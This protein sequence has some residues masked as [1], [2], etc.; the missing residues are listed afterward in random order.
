MAN[1]KKSYPDNLL[2]RLSFKDNHFRSCIIIEKLEAEIQTIEHPEYINSVFKD[3]NTFV[4][5]AE[6]HGTTVYKLKHAIEKDL[7]RL[8]HPKHF[9]N[10]LD[11]DK[12]HNRIES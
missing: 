12:F 10:Y 4:H 9:R 2:D 7:R 3:G 6:L 1:S 11:M 5:A 8:H